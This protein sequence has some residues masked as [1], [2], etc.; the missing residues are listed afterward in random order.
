MI[1]ESISKIGLGYMLNQDYK[2]SL[3]E[4]DELEEEGEKEAPLDPLAVEE[5]EGEE[6][7]AEEEQG[8]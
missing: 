2:L 8:M 4:A 3:L 6:K 7:P 1:R 5:G